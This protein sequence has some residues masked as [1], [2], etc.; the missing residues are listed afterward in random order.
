[1][2][3]II[4]V[5]LIVA[6]L[7][8]AGCGQKQEPRTLPDNAGAAPHSLHIYAVN[9]PLAWAAEQLLGSTDAVYFPVPADVDPA[10]WEPSLASIAE[11][12]QADMIL[13]NGASYAGWLSR[14]SLPENRLVDTSRSFA[15]ELLAVESGPVHSHGPEGAH[16]HDATA[17]TVWMDLSLYAQQV[18]SIGAA[19]SS[20]L[21]QQAATIAARQKEL[22]ARLPEL[23][24]QL[25]KLGS[26]FQGAPVLY[27]HPVYQ[28]F[29]QRYKFNGR[30]LHWEPDKEPSAEQWSAFRNLLQQHA[31]TVMLWEEDPLPETRDRLA[32]LGVA[33]VVFRP[34]GN[35]PPQ[36]DFASGMSANIEAL[37][38]YRA[39]A[40]SAAMR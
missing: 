36:G 33:V 29:Q 7:L 8:L 1:M 22:L 14:V 39:A 2:T 10:T 24:A 32:A 31:A 12:Q 5:G 16:S 28:Y 37:R 15:R 25:Q 11:Y 27:S 9:Y 3:Y 20:H 6:L 40:L 13:L 30:A 17:A 4:Q 34:M 19:L 23:D 35:R 38:A 26:E 21:P 18:E